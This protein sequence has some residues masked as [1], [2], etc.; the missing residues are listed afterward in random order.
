MDSNW[1]LITNYVSQ[2]DDYI[3]MFQAE[4]L[5]IETASIKLA[6]IEFM[7]G[8]TTPDAPFDQYLRG[9]KCPFRSPQNGVGNQNE[10]CIRCHQGT[11]IGGGMVMRDL[12]ILDYQRQVPNEAKIKAALCLPLNHKTSTYSVLLALETSQ[13]QHPTFTMDKPLR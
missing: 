11:N 7:Q 2:S 3:N 9:Y 4:Q 6:L 5:P 1:E 8:L 10:G 13:S 12:D